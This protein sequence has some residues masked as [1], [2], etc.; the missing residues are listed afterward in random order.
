MFLKPLSAT[1]KVIINLKQRILFKKLAIKKI[2]ITLILPLFFGCLNEVKNLP[3]NFDYGTIGNGSYANNYFE[4]TVSF[5]PD[6]KIG[7]EEQMNKIADK[8]KDLI[9]G[10]DSEL[11]RGIKAAEVNSA[12][13]LTVSRHEIGTTVEFNPSLLVVAENI[14]NFPEIKN[15]SDY[16]IQTKNLLQQSQINYYFEKAVYKKQIGTLTFHVLEGKINYGT[17]VVTQEYYTTI[18]KGFS[19]SFIISYAN[20]EDKQEL[21]TIIESIKI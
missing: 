20:E 13:L 21:D 10:D 19:L 1:Y 14:K 16:L 5:N 7:S 18:T 12:Y 2:I 6:W 15:G 17:V 3:E 4:M 9:A 8:G 11:K